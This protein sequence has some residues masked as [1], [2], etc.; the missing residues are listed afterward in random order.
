MT[1]SHKSRLL[2]LGLIA[3]GALAFIAFLG[4]TGDGDDDRS[5]GLLDWLVAGALIG[6]GFGYLIKWRRARVIGCSSTAYRP[7]LC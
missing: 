3:V 5:F 2:A 1:A 7:I 6:P 4:I